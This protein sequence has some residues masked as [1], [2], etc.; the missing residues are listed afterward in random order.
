MFKKIIEFGK[1]L[2]IGVIFLV[3]IHLMTDITLNGFLVSIVFGIIF[4][5]Y[6][7]TMKTHH[8][9]LIISKIC[10]ENNY[11]FN[12]KY[13]NF[14]Q[15]ITAIR[16]KLLF[17]SLSIA[18]PLSKKLILFKSNFLDNNGIKFLDDINNF[19]NISINE[20]M[21]TLIIVFIWAIFIMFEKRNKNYD[22][23]LEVRKNRTEYEKIDEKYRI[24]AGEYTDEE[25]KILNNGKDLVT[26]DSSSNNT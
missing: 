14:V 21:I 19:L 25:L 13:Y 20:I 17:S 2:L 9:S 7:F 15:S 6:W 5:E 8:E 10:T 3:F 24:Y 16:W 22:K 11:F 12:E 1:T 23:L 26:N 4:C 18:L